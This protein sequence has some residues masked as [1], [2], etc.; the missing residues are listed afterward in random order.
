MISAVLRIN[1]CLWHAAAV[2]AVGLSIGAWDHPHCFHSGKIA[3]IGLCCSDYMYA[4]E[5][6]AKRQYRACRIREDAK[7]I[8]AGPDRTIEF[9]DT[10]AIR[11]DA[12]NY[13]GKLE[14]VA[15][16]VSID[17]F[18]AYS[19]SCLRYCL[20]RQR[21]NRLSAAL[22]SSLTKVLVGVSRAV[23]V[24]RTSP[25]MPTVPARRISVLRS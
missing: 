8:G 12:D 5:Q 3:L 9:N 24:C 23:D 15:H 13:P 22:W 11:L 2:R 25:P 19:S 18:G 1:D 21:R 16:G 6:I 14:F 7:C 4:W 10:E 17:L 20:R